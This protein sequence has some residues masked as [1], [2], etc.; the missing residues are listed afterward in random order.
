MFDPTTAELNFRYEGWHEEE[1][2][3]G[4]HGQVERVY[5]AVPKAIRNGRQSATFRNQ[6]LRRCGTGSEMSWR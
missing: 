3:E 2:S 5:Y 4:S 1:D 6:L